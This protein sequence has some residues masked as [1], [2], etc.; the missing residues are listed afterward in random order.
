MGVVYKAE[1]TNLRCF[2]DKN[3]VKGRFSAT[4]PLS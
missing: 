3:Q 1:D 4:S 2:G